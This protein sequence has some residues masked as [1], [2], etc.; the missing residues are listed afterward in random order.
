MSPRPYKL[1]RRQAAT[2]ETRAKILAAAR[3]GLIAPGGFTAF[4]L[5]AVARAADVARMTVYNQ[6]ESKAGLLAALFD[7]MAVVK[8]RDQII[9]AMSLPDPLDALVEAFAGFWTED[10]AIQRRLHAL[11][12][13]DEEVARALAERTERMYFATR[14]I[15]ARHGIEPGDTEAQQL[16][17][18]LGFRCMDALA[19]PRTP[20]EIVPLIQRLAR[21]LL[22]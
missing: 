4:T 13:L 5:E 16:A 12:E 7:E 8:G 10:R 19:G 1:G 20:A 18:L 21:A 22:V 9:V 3:A 14:T 17:A 11:A 2:E 15:V 6:F